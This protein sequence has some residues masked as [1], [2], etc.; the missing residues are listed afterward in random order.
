MALPINLW[1]ENMN[2]KE[3]KFQKLV[4]LGVAL[5]S[6]LLITLIIVLASGRNNPSIPVQDNIVNDTRATSQ[7]QTEQQDIPVAHEEQEVIKDDTSS[8]DISI[9]TRAGEMW[10]SGS[11]KIMVFFRD[12]DD[13]VNVSG[14]IR[15]GYRE[16]YD[17][18]RADS[19]EEFIDMTI[20][21]IAKSNDVS[22]LDVEITGDSTVSIELN[23]DNENSIE[24]FRRELEKLSFVSEANYIDTELD[25][26]AFVV[27]VMIIKEPGS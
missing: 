8:D 23:S 5:V 3:T 20:E 13:V 7:P 11:H 26:E 14:F 18:V 9:G 12:F 27:I 1:E 2:L 25:D 24:R 21:R 15:G 16:F 4:L 6:V 10:V 17:A 22:I 19:G